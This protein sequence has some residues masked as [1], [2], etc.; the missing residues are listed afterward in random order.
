MMVRTVSVVRVKVDSSECLE[1]VMPWLRRI[2]VLDLEIY[3]YLRK[4]CWTEK[5]ETL[6]AKIGK[7]EF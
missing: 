6:A 1:G 7:R 4:W 3:G 2:T 5:M